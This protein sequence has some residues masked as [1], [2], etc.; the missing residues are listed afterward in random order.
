MDMR[1]TKKN[2]LNWLRLAYDVLWL[3]PWIAKSLKE[4]IDRT[5]TVRRSKELDEIFGGEEW[6]IL[7]CADETTALE[8]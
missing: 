4:Y 3:E 8:E 5:D 1:V 7:L 2:I 6:S